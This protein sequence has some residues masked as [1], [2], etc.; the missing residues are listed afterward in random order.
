MTT[1][2]HLAQTNKQALGQFY[3]TCADALLSNTPFA[4]ERI[5]LG[6]PVLDPFAG[7]GNLLDWA[8]NVGA[9]TVRGY[10]L[11]PKRP[12]FICRDTLLDPPDYKG[13]VV[14]T[15]PPYLNANKCRQGDKRPYAKWD[16]NDYYKCFLASLEPHG[17]DEALVILPGNFICESR[18]AA[19]RRLFETHHIVSAR[20]WNQQTFEDATTSICVLHLRRGQRDFQSFSL[21]L[22]QENLVV[23]VVLEDKYNYLWGKD[24]FDYIEGHS[25]IVVKT[26]KGMPE[27]NT[28]MVLSLLDWGRWPSGL[29]FNSGDPIYCNPNSFTTYQITLPQFN[30]TIT[31]QKSVVTHFNAKLTQYRSQ[32]YDLFLANYMGPGQKILSRGYMHALLGRVL[33][34]LWIAPSPRQSAPKEV[35]IALDKHS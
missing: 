17:C 7:Q 27:P 34:D 33:A 23:P 31:Q 8:K 5:V 35:Q 24:F 4:Y 29:N 25:I 21:N 11:F 32:Y 6:R 19:R 16:T 9:T 12:A 18:G 3:T 26:D 20:Y 1:K 28:R 30:L 13:F 10:D 15:N 14:V 2:R 22:V